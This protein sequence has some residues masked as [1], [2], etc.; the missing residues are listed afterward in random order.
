MRLVRPA[1]QLADGR[2]PKIGSN[3]RDH[4]QRRGGSNAPGLDIVY[5]GGEVPKGT[6]AIAAAPGT[7]VLVKHAKRGVVVSISLG[8]GLVMTYRHL[9]VPEVSVGDKVEAGQALGLISHDPLD[10]A[11]KRHLHFEMQHN[12][13]FIDPQPLFDL[14]PSGRAGQPITQDTSVTA[15]LKAL[16]QG[17]ARARAARTSSAASELFRVP[18]RAHPKGTAQWEVLVIVALLLMSFR[19]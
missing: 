16:Q 6:S 5:P 12:K 9:R 14:L 4:L 15:L 8:R 18:S 7:V 13:E 19:N 1:E 2:A 10:R 17:K 11:K 3:F